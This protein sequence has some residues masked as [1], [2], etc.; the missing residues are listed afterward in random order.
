MKTSC[1]VYTYIRQ[2]K[3]LTGR[4]E[5]RWASVE[6]NHSFNLLKVFVYRSRKSKMIFK[7]GLIHHPCA[8]CSELPSYMSTMG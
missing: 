2:Q 3:K 6:R 1:K 8:T 5:S 7:K 4:S